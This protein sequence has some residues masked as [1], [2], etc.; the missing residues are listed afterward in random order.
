MN[1]PALGREHGFVIH[2]RQRR[3]R[4]DR[5]VDFVGSEFRTHGQRVL[6]DQLGRV[7]ADDVRTMISSY[8]SPSST[9]TKP[10]ES[11]AATAL[12]LAL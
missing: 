3:M 9:L 6:G 11:P 10:S 7:R 1:R 2:L 12:P 8:F 5:G 4:V